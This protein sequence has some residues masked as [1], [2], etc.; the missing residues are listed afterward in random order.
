[1]FHLPS[2]NGN[3]AT[4]AR[5]SAPTTRFDPIRELTY[6]RPYR[7][8]E[9]DKIKNL[10]LEVQAGSVDASLSAAPQSGSKLLCQGLCRAQ[11]LR[12]GRR[13]M[14]RGLTKISRKQLVSQRIPSAIA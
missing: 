2:G 9:L 13:A 3:P 5:L 7:P 6:E 1:M 8:T 14:K 11:F 12:F 10:Q 4:R